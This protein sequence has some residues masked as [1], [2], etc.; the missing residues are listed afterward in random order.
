MHGEL[1]AVSCLLTS[2]IRSEHRENSTQ[3]YV[4]DSMGSSAGELSVFCNV[5]SIV[6]R[7]HESVVSAVPKAASCHAH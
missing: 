7:A 6:A 1:S 3:L 2:G 5:A 4:R